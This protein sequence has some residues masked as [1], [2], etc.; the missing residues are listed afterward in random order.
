MW[1]GPEIAQPWEATVGKLVPSSVGVI[2][3]DDGRGKRK[4]RLVHDLRRSHI[5]S[6]ISYQERLVLPRLCDAIEDILNM[7][8]TRQAHEQVCLVVLDVK[9]AFKQLHVRPSERKYLH[10]P[11]SVGPSCGLIVGRLTQAL[12]GPSEARLQIYMDDPFLCLKGTTKALDRETAKVRVVRSNKSWR[13]TT[14]AEGRE[15]KMTGAHGSWPFWLQGHSVLFPPTGF[16][17]LS[18]HP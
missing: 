15:M 6:H 2:V 5:N 7:L 9:D 13:E 3:K 14:R 12:I 11:I 17:T 4:V 16:A 8:E 1:S 10:R 18:S